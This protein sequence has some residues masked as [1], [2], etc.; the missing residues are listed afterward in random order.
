MLP[1][2][3]LLQMQGE[4][5][6]H[7]KSDALQAQ[8]HLQMEDLEQQIRDLSFYVSTREKVAA[9][10]SSLRD[11]LSA[12][13]VLGIAEGKPPQSENAGTTRGKGS[14]GKKKKG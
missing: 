2:D 9:S 4:E 3:W 14:S 11:E 13:V 5:E 8:F 6:Y 10:P 7:Q 12:G 1:A